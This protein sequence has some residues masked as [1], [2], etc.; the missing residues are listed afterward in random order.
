M[1]KIYVDDIGRTISVSLGIDLT[2][3][4]VRQILVYKP[5]GQQVTWT[6]TLVGPASNGVLQYTTIAGDLNCSGAWRIQGYV[7][8]AGGTIKEKG[9]T[10]IFTVYD[11]WK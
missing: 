1:S 10:S 9:E 11:Q 4:T 3:M 2:L 5:N 8:N 7:E 6:G